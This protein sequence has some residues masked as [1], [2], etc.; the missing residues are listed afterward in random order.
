MFNG[1]ILKMNNYYNGV[2]K[3]LEKFTKLKGEMFLC[4]SCLKGRGSFYRPGAFQII[5]S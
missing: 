5:M 2:S 3:V 4:P 1:L